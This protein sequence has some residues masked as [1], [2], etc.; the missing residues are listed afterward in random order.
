MMYKKIIVL[1]LVLITLNACSAKNILQDEAKD[2]RIYNV[3]PS[4]KECKYIEEIIGSEANIINF[5]FM[6]NKDMTK[7]ARADLRNQARELGANT[8][9]VEN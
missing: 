8:V 4:D 1:L 5:L 9:V 3:L 2:V 6:S 7:G